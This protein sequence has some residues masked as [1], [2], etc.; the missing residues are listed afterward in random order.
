MQ[1]FVRDVQ[2]SKEFESMIFIVDGI[3]ISF[4]EVQPEKVLFSIFVIHEGRFNSERDEHPQKIYGDKKGTD[5]FSNDLQFMKTPSP[6]DVTELGTVI[7]SN[8]VHS[9]KAISP[10]VDNVDGNVIFLGGSH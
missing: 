3:V 1:T 6:S 9:S 4:N 2:R 7:S 8:D 5:Y 10:I